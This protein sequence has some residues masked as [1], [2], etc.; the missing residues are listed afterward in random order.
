MF[1]EEC[2]CVIHNCF[3]ERLT[4]LLILYSGIIALAEDIISG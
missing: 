3:P 2:Q 4:I 1:A